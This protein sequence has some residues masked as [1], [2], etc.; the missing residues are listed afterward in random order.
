MPNFDDN[1]ITL[2]DSYKVSHAVQY[3]PKT[4]KIYSYLES[5]GGSDS[6]DETCF[7]GLQYILKRYLTGQ[8]VTQEKI[9]KAAKRFQ[10]HFGND[11]VFQRDRWEYILNKHNGRLPISIKAVAEGTVVPTHNALMTI[12]NTD[13]ECFWLTNYLETIIQQVWAPLTV[14]TYSRDCKMLILKYLRKT[15]NPDLIGF[16]LHDFGFRGVSSVETSA[17]LGASHLV[18]FMGTDTF[19]AVELLDEYYYEEMAGFSIPAAEHSTITSWGKDNE[20]RAF[21][22]MLEQ[23]PEGLVAVVSDSYNIYEACEKLWGLT[24]RNEVLNRKGTLVVRPDCYD[25]ETECL[26]TNGW[27][28]IKDVSFDDS[29]AQYDNNGNIE[30]VTP[31]KLHSYDYSG[32]MVH[33]YSKKKRIDLL[34]TPNHRMVMVN[35]D[36]SNIKIVEAQSAKYFFD[37]NIL[38]SGFKVSGKK[39]ILTPMERLLIAFQAD[40]SYPSDKNK[41]DNPGYLSGH[42]SIRFNFA[43][44]RKIDRLTDILEQGDFDYSIHDEPSRIGQ[45]TF[46]VK[47]PEYPPKDFSWVKL[48]EITGEWAREFIEELSYWDSTRRSSVRFKYDTTNEKCANVVQQITSIG[49]MGCSYSIYKDDRQECFNDVHSLTILMHNN[50]IGGQSINKEI[51]KGFSGKVYCLTVPSGMVLV[52]R[53][54]QVVVSGNSGEPPYVVCKVLDILGNKFGYENNEKG[55]KVLNDHVRVIQGDG[56]N[57]QMLDNILFR[58]QTHGW[59]ADNVAFGSGGALLQK[60]H[61]DTYKIAIK[62]SYAVVDGK[63]IEVYKNPVDDPGKIS[64]K[65]RLALVKRDGI[66]ITLPEDSVQSTENYLVEVFNNGNIVVDHKF[67]EIRKRSE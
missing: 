21:R 39:T 29:V 14:C 16:K 48:E 38:R 27:K 37:R 51:V 13:P 59:S 28:Y 8:V 32:D 19:S 18:N 67:S 31:L 44:Q 55:F 17:I 41:I 26:T 52:R 20:V 7:F 65:G 1:I 10:L 46:Y 30:F 12:E 62:C 54:R 45:K 56:I 24:L 42:V 36:K 35:N 43:K 3:P 25:E 23:Y 60:H 66:F 34:V 4:T 33:F 9:D 22:N 6:S 40:G 47:L 63:E 64:K 11:K 15:G 5:R 57:K 58:M 50:L 53:N 2:T 49:D 61:R